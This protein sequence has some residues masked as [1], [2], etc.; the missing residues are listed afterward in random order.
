MKHNITIG[1]NLEGSLNVT[2]G[3]LF[4]AKVNYNADKNS[5]DCESKFLEE[6]IIRIAKQDETVLYEIKDTDVRLEIGASA[7]G[8]YV[9]VL[10]RQDDSE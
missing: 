3:D 6:H 4:V 9:R 10:R 1:G 7:S 5:I 8:V 2:G